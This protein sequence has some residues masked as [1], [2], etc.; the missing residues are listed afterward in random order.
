[1]LFVQNIHPCQSAFSGKR[2]KF[3]FIQAVI[4][5]ATIVEVEKSV[6]LQTSKL[7]QETAIQ[8]GLFLTKWQNL[9]GWPWLKVLPLFP[10]FVWLCF[11]VN[12]TLFYSIY[13]EVLAVRVYSRCANEHN[14]LG[15]MLGMAQGLTKLPK[16]SNP[17][18]KWI[19]RNQ[20]FLNYS[21]MVGLRSLL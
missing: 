7:L 16:V 21:K 20:F 18:P 6:H 2:Q 11:Q 1:M 15:L 10:Q 17:G 13:K 19:K 5:W 9:D 8:T 14:C 12:F 4:F 3:D